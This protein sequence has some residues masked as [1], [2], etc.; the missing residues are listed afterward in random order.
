M[1]LSRKPII[2]F[3][4]ISIILLII[5]IIIFLK[6]TNVFPI[7][8]SFCWI[9]CSI[10][11]L[12]IANSLYNIDSYNNNQNIIFSIII[13]VLLIGCFLCSVGLVWN[14]S[15]IPEIKLNFTT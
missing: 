13:Y 14:A 3:I 12:L 9:I 6:K 11:T 10:L 5:Y 1:D 8:E 4:I 7:S 15:T 2:S